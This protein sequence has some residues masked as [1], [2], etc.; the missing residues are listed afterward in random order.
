MSTLW[1]AGCNM[2]HKINTHS[3][4]FSSNYCVRGRWEKGMGI[5]PGRP[6]VN[7]VVLGQAQGG[8]VQ[9]PISK[10]HTP[11]CFQ[12]CICHDINASRWRCLAGMLA[13]ITLTFYLVFPT[14]ISCVILPWN[15]T[16]QATHGLN[17]NDTL[18]TSTNAYHIKC[19]FCMKLTSVHRMSLIICRW[20]WQ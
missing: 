19:T 18:N 16:K 7:C 4:N 5:D 2:A 10:G 6:V 13:Y 3:P 11:C 1:S 15:Q 9:M 14:K 17:P 12:C 20:F 8:M